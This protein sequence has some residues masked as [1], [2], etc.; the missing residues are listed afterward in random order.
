MKDKKIYVVSPYINGGGSRSLHQLSTILRNKN[1]DVKIVYSDGKTILPIDKLLYDDTNL[2]IAN[3]II[4]DI[5]NIVIIP[6]AFTGFLSNY[7]NA[8]KIIWWLS[9]YYYRIN[10]V[11]WFTKISIARRGL[12]KIVYP[13]ILIKKYCDSIGKI[14]EFIKPNNLKNYYHLYNNELVHEYLLKNDVNENNMLYLCGPLLKQYINNNRKDIIS[15]K[16]NIVVYNEVKNDKTFI[17]LISKKIKK[18][19]I[20]VISINN[21]K[22]DEVYQL[23]KKAKV[24]IDFGYHPGVE[25]MPREAVSLYCNIITSNIGTASNKIDVPIDN[26][27]KFSIKYSNIKKIV[28]LIVNMTNNY[29]EYIDDFNVFR[30][31][32]NEQYHIFDDNCNM[33]IERFVK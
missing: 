18:Y 29:N 3:N 28:N 27:Y 12:P 30:N 32:I 17:S 24:Y 10:D 33:L 26:K 9:Y 14:N 4:D 8:I 22:Q 16:E 13:F 20:N 7:K 5:N 2:E 21:M 11:C 23:L 19:G 1:V 25:R 15:K 6:E 31:K